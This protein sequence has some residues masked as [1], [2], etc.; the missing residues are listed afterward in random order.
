MKEE[1]RKRVQQFFA[2]DDFN[3]CKRIYEAV[4]NKFDEYKGVKNG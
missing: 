1:Y 4:R 3:N 2:F